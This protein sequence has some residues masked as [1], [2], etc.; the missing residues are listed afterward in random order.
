[1]WGIIRSCDAART[2]RRPEASSLWRKKKKKTKNTSSRL[3]DLPFKHEGRRFGGRRAK[4]KLFKSPT[5]SLLV[6]GMSGDTRGF[7]L[8]NIFFYRQE[9]S[10]GA[11]TELGPLTASGHGGD[12]RLEKEN[13]TGSSFFFSC[14]SVIAMV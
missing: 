11:C 5:R 14:H 8:N 2:E 1:M 7:N 6:S 12:V 9:A 13:R 4:V 10:R 3:W